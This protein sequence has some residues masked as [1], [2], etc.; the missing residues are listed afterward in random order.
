MIWPFCSKPR[1]AR[2]DL[3]PFCVRARVDGGYELQAFRWRA[4][5]FGPPMPSYSPI[6]ETVFATVEAAQNHL[7]LYQQRAAK[8]TGLTVAGVIVGP[9]S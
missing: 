1:N 4:N 5:P 7:R 2:A 8:N 9:S 3:P 6:T